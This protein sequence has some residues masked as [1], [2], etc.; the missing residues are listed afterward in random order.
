MVIAELVQLCE[1][2]ALCS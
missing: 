2:Y 1:A